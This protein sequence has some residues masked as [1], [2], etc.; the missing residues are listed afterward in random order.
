MKKIIVLIIV[1]AVIISGFSLY[2][3][4]EIRW[5]VGKTLQ[6]KEGTSP[7]IKDSSIN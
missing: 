3:Q 2:S 4:P 7:Q 1:V 5:E 6:V